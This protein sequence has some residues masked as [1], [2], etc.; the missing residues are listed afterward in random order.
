MN[1]AT[2]TIKLSIAH[3]LINEKYTSYKE[4]LTGEE[5]ISIAKDLKLNQEDVNKEL[6]VNTC[7]VIDGNTITYRDDFQGAIYRVI[8]DKKQHPLSWD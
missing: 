1:T 8:T 7:M 2:Q 4:G 6:G 3:S 5:M